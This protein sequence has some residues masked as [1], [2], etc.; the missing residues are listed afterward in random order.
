MWKDTG[1]YTGVLFI[2]VPHATVSVFYLC[3]TTSIPTSV[4]S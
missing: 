2:Y 4:S 1:N 3:T